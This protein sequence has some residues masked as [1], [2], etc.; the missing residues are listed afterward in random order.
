MQKLTRIT[1]ERVEYFLGVLVVGGDVEALVG[2]L[3]T[4]G[5]VDG[6][7]VVDD[8]RPAHSVTLTLDVEH[9]RP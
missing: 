9:L 1:D 8:L 2:A 4:A 3:G 7:D 6:H 5:H